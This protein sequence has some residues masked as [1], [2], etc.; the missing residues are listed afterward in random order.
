M[1][2]IVGLVVICL[3]AFTCLG[4]KVLTLK[5]DSKEIPIE[6]YAKVYTTFDENID[7]LSVDEKH[8]KLPQK[9]LNFGMVRKIHWIRVE[10]N[11]VAEEQLQLNFY[12][13]YHHIRSL[14]IFQS[15]TSNILNLR[16]DVGT[17][18]S[19][20]KKEKYTPGYSSKLNFP[21]GRSFIYLRIKHQNIPLRAN[22]YLL[23]DKLIEQVIQKSNV[24]YSIWRTIMLIAFT[25]S[26]VAYLI[27]RIRIFFLYLMMN[28]GI[29]LFI[30]METGLFFLTFDQDNWFS[31]IDIKHLGDIIVLYFFPLFL[32]ELTPIKK[33]NPR[34][35][36]L[37]M[38]LWVLAPIL[39]VVSVVPEVKETAF[40]FYS[41]WFLIFLTIYIFVIQL[42][43]L[44]ITFI[45]KEKN[46][47][48]LFCLYIVYIAAVTFEVIL[49]NVG[50]R[51]D[52][53][54]VYDVLL[55][56]SI[57]E[58]ILFLGLIGREM[59]SIFKDRNALLIR[60][61]ELK[62]EM[63][64]AVI[65]S[66][67]EERNVLGRELHDMIGANMSVV[68]QNTSK[69]DKNLIKIIDETIESVRSLSHGLM[70]PRVKGN[71]LKNEII[72]LCLSCSNDKLKVN[73]YFHDW[74]P[75]LNEEDATHFYRIIQELLQNVVKHSQ[76]DEVF[77]Q[78][79]QKGNSIKMSFED[80]GVGFDVRKKGKGLLGIAHRAEIL[81]A[82]MRFE[83]SSMGTLIELE[84]DR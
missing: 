68:R 2:A 52:S 81:K 33:H 47:L 84:L 66:Q 67:E 58:V 11:N 19:Y 53:V 23:K 1:K 69:E 26:L 44:L 76:A 45:K 72:D 59:Y 60:E 55:K 61:K 5:D 16:A 15:D 73:H 82:T 25:I 31:I 18:K 38:Y 35:W 51:S 71:Q 57:I 36:K 12:T 32:N 14:Q 37:T 77:L 13:P 10:V 54:Y 70:T 40:Y 49:P 4:Q 43:F 28:V 9:G 65:K 41:V 74:K 42:Y 21:V 29:T 46:S 63:L 20:S 75:I 27:T 8:W 80:N 48:I 24:N 50:V 17:T 34:L 64:Q 62:E 30:G 3:V 6:T 56:S 7:V 78:I 83:S 79:I 22:S 39:W